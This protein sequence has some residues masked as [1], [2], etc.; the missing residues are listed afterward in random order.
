[1]VLGP[2]IIDPIWKLPI[3]LN[4]LIMSMFMFVNFTGTS[5][6]EQMTLA[7]YMEPVQWLNGIF[8]VLHSTV[9]LAA[10]YHHHFLAPPIWM[11]FNKDSLIALGIYVA[12]FVVATIIRLIF[13]HRRAQ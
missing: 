9:G 11:H 8:F 12:L 3:S 4:L 2:N 6:S 1:M 10:P 5:P 7:D 13:K